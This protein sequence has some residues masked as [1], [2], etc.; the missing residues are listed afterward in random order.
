MST[1]RSVY[2]THATLATALFPAQGRQTPVLVAFS[3]TSDKAGSV[4]DVYTYDNTKTTVD[5]SSASGQTVLSVTATTGFDTSDR[6]L[7]Q[8]ANGTLE[9]GVVNTIQAGVSL[10]LTANLVNTTAV[11][12]VVFELKKVGTFACGATTVANYGGPNGIVGGVPGSP[13]VIVLDGTSACSIN[14][15]TVQYQ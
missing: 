4:V 1:Y 8:H 11:G 13:M 5:A 14:T 15:A 10:T 6:I 2:A 12:A 3:A 9:T 7:I